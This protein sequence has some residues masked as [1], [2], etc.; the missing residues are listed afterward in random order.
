LRTAADSAIVY[1]M[2]RPKGKPTVQVLIR[3]PVELV[4]PLRA[5]ADDEGVSVTAHVVQLVRRDLRLAERRAKR[6][7]K[8]EG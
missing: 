2:P 8:R 5:R 1:G 3:M 7:P 6:A 4:D